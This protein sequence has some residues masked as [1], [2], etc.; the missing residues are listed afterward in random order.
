MLYHQ[1]GISRLFYTEVVLQVLLQ[2]A[3]LLGSRH[4]NLI[5]WGPAPL[6]QKHVSQF[7]RA[8]WVSILYT[9]D[10]MSDRARFLWSDIVLERNLAWSDAMVI[11]IVALTRSVIFMVS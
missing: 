2:M 7:S 5:L 11:S 3:I 1:Y 8:G 4:V 9:D 10:C 6:A